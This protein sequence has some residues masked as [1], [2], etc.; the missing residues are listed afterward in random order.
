MQLPLQL[1]DPPSPSLIDGVT[2]RNAAALIAL[3]QVARGPCD[4]GT[5]L[6]LWG[7]PGSGK[8]FWLS[9]WAKALGSKAVRI[10]CKPAQ[11]RPPTDTPGT[12]DT[13]GNLTTDQD[14]AAHAID[15]LM[16]GITAR[17]AIGQN[18]DPT[19]ILLDDV[20][21]SSPETAGAIFRLYNRLVEQGQ[22]MICT[23]SAPP[24]RLTL[25]DDLRT[26]LGQGLIYE[27]HELDDDD[28]KNALRERANRLGWPLSDELLSYLMTRLPRDLGLL[29]RVLDSL[30][31]L[32]LSQ[33]RAVTIPLLKEL[34]D[35]LDATHTL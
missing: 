30:D 4:A 10:Q 7:T 18:L 34:L 5:L 17:E 2:G 32:A 21:A 12:T 8:S 3:T 33:H 27:L 19:V 20:D 1:I 24:L 14:P 6:Y 26:R 23:A 31:Q 9:A 11:G 28:K 13:S 25:R 29:T 35:S 16:S 15:Q 22:R